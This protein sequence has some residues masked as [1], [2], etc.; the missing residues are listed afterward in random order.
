MKFSSKYVPHTALSDPERKGEKD[1]SGYH[2]LV[3]SVYTYG[4]VLNH[5][6]T[7]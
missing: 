4:H 5:H 7:K 2:H 3:I 6:C 1:L